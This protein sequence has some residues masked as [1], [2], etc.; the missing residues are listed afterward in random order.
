[1][2]VEAEG[3]VPRQRTGFTFGTVVAGIVIGAV[4]VVFAVA[5]AT[6][7]F[8]EYLELYFLDAGVGL[9]LGAAA[10]ALGF[11]AWRAGRRGILGGIQG[12]ATVLMAIVSASA[13]AHP[14]AAS[15]R[16]STRP[17]PRCSWRRS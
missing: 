16:S 8:G 12:P 5:F 11:M 15:R 6:L 4:E 9:Y 3:T 13:V 1:M 7:V 14:V 2:G 10:L 17:S